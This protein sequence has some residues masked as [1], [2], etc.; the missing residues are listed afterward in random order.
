MISKFRTKRYLLILVLGYVLLFAPFVYSIFYSMPANDDFAWAIDWWS[1]NRLIEALHRV[2]YNYMITYGNSGLVAILIQVLFHPLHI[3]NNVGHSF[4]ICM[5]VANVIIFTIL[6]TSVRRLFK[7]LFE[8]D[9]D[10]ALDVLTFL[11][12]A[13]VTTTY[14][15]SDVYNWWSGTPGYAGMMVMSVLTCSMM[16]KYLKTKNQKTYIAMIVFGLIACT[17]MMYD[18]LIGGFYVLMF[19]II[20]RKNQDTL[21][22]KIFPL[23]LY[24][25]MGIIQVI[26][27]GNFTRM[28][29]EDRYSQGMV[30]AI[31][32][33]IKR[34]LMRMATT[35][36]NKP[37]VVMLFIFIC[38]IGII[39][40]NKREVHF[41]NIVLGMIVTMV[42]A[43]VG[44][45]L[46]VY[47]QDKRIDS[48]FTPRIYYVEDYIIFIGCALAVFALGCYFGQ[49]F[50]ISISKNVA[51][52]VV[53]AVGVIALADIFVT[54]KYAEI[55]QVDIVAK[56]DIIRDS[57]YLWDGII[58]EV[59]AAE[60][61][62]DVVIERE[63]V[64]WCQ[65]SYYTSFDDIPRETLTDEDKY[66]TCN[67]CASKYYGVDSILVYLY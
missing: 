41:L 30:A 17:S 3:F 14:Y 10:V 40:K 42:S 59:V 13:L 50:S 37:W 39:V 8:M 2:Q 64:P 16:A 62:A 34:I 18:V 19:F 58:D 51:I 7:Y 22:K 5:I 57:Y 47:G 35:V 49:K 15:Y 55:I 24:I 1:D 45:L 27:P 25:V 63:N 20:E 9:S 53:S 43:F 52:T 60:D 29:V 11:V 28:D 67:Q 54:G 48:E 23:A 21:K 46:Y 56:A 33:T 66:G 38:L 12:T 44:V 65:Y 26:A 32:V 61:G 36:A 4:G 31:I 6:I